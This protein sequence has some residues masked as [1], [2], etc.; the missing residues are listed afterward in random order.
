MPYRSSETDAADTISKLRS[1]DIELL[2]YISQVCN[3][4]EAEEPIVQAMVP[5]SYVRERVCGDASRLL[6]QY[7]D[8]SSRPALFGV[9]IGVKDI[10]RVSGF[11]TRCGARLPPELFDGPE[12][13]CVT[14]LREAGAI[15]VGKT[16][17]AEF[18]WFEPGPTRNPYNFEHTPGGSSSGSAAGV[19]CGFFLFALG[20]Q[21]AGSTTRP[22]AYCGVVG[23][24]PTFGR[25]ST[26]GV[27]PCSPSADHVGVFGRLV[28]ELNIIL[29]IVCKDW[30]SVATGNA[31]AR[32]PVLA[33]P[34][35]PYLEQAAAN[36]REHFERHLARLQDVGYTIRRVKALDAVQDVNRSHM[37][38]ITAEM[39]RVHEEWFGLYKDLYR[40]RTAEAI[41][42]GLAIT[43]LELERCRSGRAELRRDLEKQMVSEGIELW[44][45]PS[46]TDHAPKGLASTGSPIMSIP[47]TF[48]GL[49]TISLPAGLDNENLP[50][51][52]QLVA[53]SMGDEILMSK[54]EELAKRLESL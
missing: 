43:N 13:T 20:T 39:A 44:I 49:P 17:T 40:Q 21:T 14:F 41:Q 38:M 3:R 54:S 27:V 48:A 36:A 35:G 24:K 16:V 47:W 12:A 22:A 1:G 34:E 42:E 33:V 18:A 51:G 45:C 37:R 26:T 4:L 31:A 5:G 11:P 50:L 30:R 53:P 23:F 7:P 2:E 9:P 25:I 52:I 32:K 46:T 29:P 19:A 8:P 28:S 15:I 10:F 6:D